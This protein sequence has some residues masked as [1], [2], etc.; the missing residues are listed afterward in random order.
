MK[1]IMR[2]NSYLA[3]FVWIGLLAACNRNTLEL[4][5]ISP[6]YRSVSYAYAVNQVKVIQ[7]VFEQH[8]DSF[9]MPVKLTVRNILGQD[10]TDIKL[11]IQVCENGEADATICEKQLWLSIDNLEAGTDRPETLPFPIHDIATAKIKVE[12][13]SIKPLNTHPYAGIYA[14]HYTQYETSEAIAG[15]GF[16]DGYINADGWLRFA[17]I[18]PSGDTYWLH[19]KLLEEV[20]LS[21]GKWLN[22]DSQFLS[23]VILDDDEFQ[24]S[25]NEL[26]FRIHFVTP[27][28]IGEDTITHVIFH[29]KKDF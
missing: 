17:C 19:A 5:P 26:S 27:Q 6:K 13:F 16:A 1:K 22:I 14:S 3:F 12:I 18:A 20:A 9:Y 24:F 28:L 23:P 7:L 21:G 25:E 29:V 10:L 11:R 2:W 8:L 15:Y 4:P